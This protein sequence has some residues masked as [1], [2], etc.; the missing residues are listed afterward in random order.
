MMRAQ[1]QESRLYKYTL[2][3]SIVVATGFNHFVHGETMV[4]F[5]EQGKTRH[6]DEVNWTRFAADSMEKCLKRL[7]IDDDTRSE[8]SSTSSAGHGPNFGYLLNTTLLSLSKKK[9]EELLKQRDD[10]VT[11]AV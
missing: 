7:T 1:H 3:A 2:M 4:F 9:K 6:W 8:A 11:R 10:K 5:R